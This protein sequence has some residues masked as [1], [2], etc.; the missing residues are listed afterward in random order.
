MEGRRR[1]REGGVGEREDGR[2]RRG[3]REGGWKGK[4]G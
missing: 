1:G 4:E 3:R 2:G